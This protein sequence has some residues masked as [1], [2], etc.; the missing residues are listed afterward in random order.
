[1]L[2]VQ[3]ACQELKG[4]F[5][6]RVQENLPQVGAGAHILSQ[7]PTPTSYAVGDGCTITLWNSNDHTYVVLSPIN[8]DNISD[9]PYYGSI[10]ES[11]Y[12][13]LGG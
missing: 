6:G 3:L 9:F 4:R 5:V 1:M 13:A 8:I 7:S 11:D 2:Q 12:E 10:A